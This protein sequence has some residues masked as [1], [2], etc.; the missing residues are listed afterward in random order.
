MFMVS[1]NVVK[2]GLSADGTHEVGHMLKYTHTL[3]EATAAQL[4]SDQPFNHCSILAI[5][6]EMWPPCSSH[7]RHFWAAYFNTCNQ[8]SDVCNQ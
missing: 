4:H 3:I 5:F 8:T 7:W 1:L 6:L 2:N